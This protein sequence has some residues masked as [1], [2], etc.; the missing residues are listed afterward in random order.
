MAQRENASE[1][2]S[3]FFALDTDFIDLH[4]MKRPSAVIDPQEG[5]LKQRLQAGE[6]FIKPLTFDPKLHVKART[7]FLAHAMTE[8]Q[9]TRM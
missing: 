7:V 5:D 9:A 8:D 2:M 3:R 4:Q 6:K 1:D